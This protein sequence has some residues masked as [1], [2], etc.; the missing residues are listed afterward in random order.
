M[1]FVTKKSILL[2]LSSSL[3]VSCSA[4]TNTI[5]QINKDNK[6]NSESY[7]TGNVKFKF[8]FPVKFTTDNPAIKKAFGVK[9]IEV[10]KINRVKVKVESATT[11]YLIERNVEL[12][13]GGVEATLSLPLDKLYTVTV[14]GLNDTDPVS[15]AEIKG[16]FSLNSSAITPSVEVSQV[17]TPVAKIIQ[18][19]KAKLA[20]LAPTTTT[21]AASTALSP[22]TGGTVEKATPT[23]SASPDPNASVTPSPTPTPDLDKLDK[24]LVTPDGKFN[25]SNIDT[26]ALA[27]LVNRARGAAHPSLINVDSFVDAIIQ[28]K[29]VPVEVPSNPLLKPGSIKGTVSGLKYNEVAIITVN[30]PASKQTIVVT[31]PQVSQSSD[32]SPDPDKVAPDVNFVVDNVTPGSWDVSVVA[33]GYTLSGTSTTNTKTTVTSDTQST[34]SFSLSSSAWPSTPINISGSVGNSDEANLALDDAGNMHLV[35]RQDGFDTDTDSGVIYYSRWNGTSWTTQGINISQYNNSGLKGAG[36]PSVAVGIDRLPQVVWTGKDSSGNKYA[37][38]NKFNGTTWQSPVSIPG[39]QDANS[40]SVAVDKTNGFL[41]AVWE[42]N[43]T[44]YLSQFDKTNWSSPL[45]VGNGIIPI[46]RMGT[47]GIVHIVWKSDVSQKLQY[48]SWTLSK[49]LS[50]V[51]DLPMTTLGSDTSNSIDAA[52][53][54]FNRLHVV[55]RNDIYVQYSLRSNVSWSQPEIV[56]QLPTALMSAKSGASISVAP[57]G[58]VNVAWV[59][60]TADDKQVIRFRRRLTDG[61]KKPFK[62]IADSTEPTV[63]SNTDTTTTTTTDTTTVTIKHSENI[64]GYEDIPLSNITSVDGKPLICADAIG[65]IHVIWSNKGDDS[66]D[67]DLLHSI[68]ASSGTTTN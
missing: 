10:G 36:N 38:F 20:T 57:T 47:D 13:P 42:S 3:L 30:D 6:L 40:V 25:L 29:G 19:L 39:S 9:S 45:T 51:E 31:P 15:G 22:T 35:W 26:S 24:L 59:S 54:R 61:W 64:D 48:A 12:V 16:Y 46:V 50:K 55:W 27:E 21:D 67:T 4:P 53:D 17:T 52:I 14:Q 7:N 23:E 63:I 65:K 18:G 28:T 58:I 41:Y 37:Y 43:N 56:N 60:T 8:N 44:I 62:R 68:K 66:N 2:L 11:S 5:T 1:R 32:T 49:G 34:A 33:S